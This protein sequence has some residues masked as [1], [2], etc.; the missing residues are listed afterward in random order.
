MSPGL[1]D[2]YNPNKWKEI[3]RIANETLAFARNEAGG[4]YF[5]QVESRLAG[6]PDNP[7]QQLVLKQ[8]HG[9]TPYPPPAVFDR[10]Q[11]IF[12]AVIGNVP[13]VPVTTYVPAKKKPK[14]KP[15]PSK[16]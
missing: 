11:Q 10:A 3:G 4:D 1:R 13:A 14:S 6:T 2:A 16:K 8:N 7:G 12:N 9:T 15:K 5:T